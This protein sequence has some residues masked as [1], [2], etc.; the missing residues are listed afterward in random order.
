MGVSKSVGLAMISAGLHSRAHTHTTCRIA[1]TQKMLKASKPPAPWTEHTH[2]HT[3]RDTR[4]PHSI[5]LHIPQSSTFSDSPAQVKSST[6][7]S[8]PPRK[9]NPAWAKPAPNSPSTPSPP[10]NTSTKPPSRCGSRPYPGTSPLP[11]LSRV[12][13][14]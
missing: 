1:T 2:T 3:H 9:T 10:S 11:A 4:Q 14:R 6:S 5:L 13:M 7:P 8:T 12:R